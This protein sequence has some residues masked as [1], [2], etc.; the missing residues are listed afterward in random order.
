MKAPSLTLPQRLLLEQCKAWAPVAEYRFHTVRRWRL[1][2]AFPD[3]K[4]GVEIDGGTFVQGKHSRGA[5]IRADMA[6]QAA[7][8]ALGWRLIRC[9][10]EHVNSGVALAWVRDALAA[11]LKREALR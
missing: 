2:V 6:K 4:L 1:D 7:L 8:A 9:M 3:V 11:E 5:G 10:P